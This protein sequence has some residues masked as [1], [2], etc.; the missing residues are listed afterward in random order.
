MKLRHELKHEIDYADLLALRM[1]PP[2]VAPALGLRFHI[3]E[4]LSDALF[5]CPALPFDGER[6]M[7]L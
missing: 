2:C 6:A 5:F 7:A 1:L 4:L 3:P